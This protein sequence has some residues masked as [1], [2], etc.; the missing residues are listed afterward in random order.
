MTEMFMTEQTVFE[1][2]QSTFGQNS[3]ITII[4]VIL[5]TNSIFFLI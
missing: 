3:D 4:R 1:S 5:K 2:M